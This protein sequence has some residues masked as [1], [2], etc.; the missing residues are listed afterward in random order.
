MIIA[1]SYGEPVVNDPAA[2]LA[3]VRRAV[4]LELEGAVL[5]ESWSNDSWVTDSL[6]LRVC[7][8]GDRGRLLREHALLASLPASIPHAQV[9]GAGR[10]GDLTW[11]TLRRIAGERLDR[12]WPRLP[13]TQRREAVISLGASLRAL[14]R[15]MPPPEIRQLIGQGSPPAGATAEAIVGSAIV[16]LPVARLFPLLD[17]IDQLPGMGAGLARRAR[18]R[19]GELQSVISGREFADG[20]VVHGDAHLANVLWR[21]GRVVGLL[22]FEWARIGP[23][24]LELEAAC[25]DNPDIEAQARR[26]SCAADD[27]PVLTWLRAGYPELFQRESLTERLWLYE[28]GG[29]IRRLCTTGA[30]SADAGQLGRLAIL[31]DRP[32]VRFS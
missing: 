31:A 7:W 10:A 19:L 1:V 16:P 32:R 14:H 18:R 26:G 25:R 6:V 12:A 5:V 15:W 4:P 23:P 3:I 2:R 13:D 17:W 8:R 20:V 21:H 27:V 28:L 24:D 29:E 22:D 30:T 9:L 11:M